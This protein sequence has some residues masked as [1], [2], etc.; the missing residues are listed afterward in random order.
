MEFTT[1][2]FIER[3]PKIAGPFTFKQL[4]FV[5]TAAIIFIFIFF[6]FKPPVILSIV[7]ALILGGASFTLA[8][9]KVGRSSLPDVMKNIFFFSFKPRIYL[10]QKKPMPSV[11]TRKKEEPQKDEEPEEKT[12]IKTEGESRLKQISSRLET[13]KQ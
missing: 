7:I 11:I 8:F 9:Y 12:K 2:Q 4:A 3:E 10:W 5:G 6:V 13:K 1:P